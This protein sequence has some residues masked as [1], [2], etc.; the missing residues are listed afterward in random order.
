MAQSSS[1]SEL[2]RTTFPQWVIATHAYGG[3]DTV[4]LKREGLIEAM[5]FL[6]DDS[7]SA[8]NVLMDLSCVDYLKFGRTPAS[9][10]SITTPSPLPYFMTPKPNAQVWERGVGPEYRFE[11]VY[12][13]YSVQRNHRLRIKVPLTEAD[14]AIDSVT[15][16]WSAANWLERE[17]WDM[18]GVR[19]NG[20]PN[21]KRILMY[22]SFQG[23]ALRKD[24]PAYK[25]QPLIGP[26]N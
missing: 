13:L 11:V 4:V 10:P 2:V 17:V 25:R 22:E 5:R 7:R 6:R 18:F 9:R 16:V 1:L 24:Y 21:L 26:L 14:P 8:F 19:F 15:T 12:H 20:H 23:H 3:N